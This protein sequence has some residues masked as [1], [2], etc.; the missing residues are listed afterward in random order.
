MNMP[1]RK[2]WM[3][4]PC[5][6][7]LRAL[8]LSH[9]WKSHVAVAVCCS[10]MTTTLVHPCDKNGIYVWHDSI[11]ICVT[12]LIH[13]GDMAHSWFLSCDKNDAWIFATQLESCHTNEQ[14]VSQILKYSQ[15]THISR[16]RYVS[17]IDASLVTRM[18]KSHR[19]Y[20]CVM[21]HTFWEGKKHHHTVESADDTRTPIHRRSDRWMSHVV[22]M[23]VAVRCCVR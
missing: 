18:N 9:E 16:H 3:N 8:F 19:T 2:Y 22:H 12:W 17:R 10:D 5:R 13:M 20:S 7:H 1:C 6:K 15:V 4:T 14:V 11:Y 21:S 23:C